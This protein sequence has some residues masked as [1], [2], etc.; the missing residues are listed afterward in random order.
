MS[1]LSISKAWDDTVEV[2]NR[3]SK[4]IVP[5]SLA[6]FAIPTAISG[7]MS[8]GAAPGEASGG[9]ALVSF[10]ILFIATVGQM[11]VARLAIG[12]KGFLGEAMTLS[13]RRAPGV[14]GAMLILV[15]PIALLFILILGGVMANA[16]ITDPAQIN[17]ETLKAMPQVGLTL[18]AL[19]IV[20][21]MLCARLFPISAVAVAE[22]AGPVALI[23][24]S[25]ALTRGHFLR[26]LGTMI[27][28]LIATFVATGALGM[29]VGTV[30]TL[31]TGPAAPF[32][33]TSLLIG[34]ANGVAAA[35][36]SAISAVLIGRIYVQLATQ[37]HVP[38][39]TR[40]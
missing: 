23:K 17:E 20:M 22:T 35:V 27:L 34:L 36:V 8:L 9:G 24:R 14:F 28:L 5:V 39:V 29:I 15:L 11:T 6:C 32:S 33:T 3:E 19:A 12:W 25:W 13:A 18:V 26:L 31:V 16:G 7:W 30:A 4:L 40:D 1:S 37:S 10:I 21:I 38:D 2:L